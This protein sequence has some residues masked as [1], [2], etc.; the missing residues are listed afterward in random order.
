MSSGFYLDWDRLK[1]WKMLQFGNYV[2]K[3]QEARYSL[4]GGSSGRHWVEFILKPE[5]AARK[6]GL[7]GARL[8][9]DPRVRLG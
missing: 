4:W 3:M 7:K 5:A 2:Q 9:K 6:A 8:R 1:M